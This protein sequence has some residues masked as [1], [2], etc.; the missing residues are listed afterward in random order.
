MMKYFFS[1]QLI[2]LIFFLSPDRVSAQSRPVIGRSVLLND[3][4][5]YQSILE[6]AHAGLYKY[7]SK[8]QIDSLF[9]HYRKQINDATD[10]CGFYRYLAAIMS[11]IGSL[12]DE[13]SLPD[14]LKKQLLA[15]QTYFPYPVKLVD[16]KLLL[17]IDGKELPAGSQIHSINGIDAGKIIQ[18]LY[19]YYTTDGFNI[20]GKAEGIN[21][22]FPWYYFMEYGP[23]TKFTINDTIVLPS[24]TMTQYTGLYKKRHS[25]LLDTTGSKSYT[26]KIIDSMETAI[27][28][29]PSFSLGNAESSTHAAY[30]KFLANSFA[31]LKSKAIRYLV[32]DIRGN[33][34][35]TDPNDLLTFSYLAHLPFKE[36]KEAFTIFQRIPYPQYCTD[37]TADIRELEENFLDEHNQYRDGRYYQNPAYSQWWRPD[38][39]AFQGKVYLLVDPAVASAASLFASMVK[40]EGNACV[41]GQE[42]M[43]GYY[44]HT[45]HNSLSYRLPGSGIAVDIS[46]V[47]LKQYVQQKREIP[48]G[49]GVIPDKIIHISTEDIKTNHDVVLDS[50]LLLIR[51]ARDHISRKDM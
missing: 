21:V 36:N 2:L 9:A 26:F 3:F 45:G 25:L 43:G 11:Y 15:E 4:D 37:D 24:V 13:V 33:G 20:T 19:K 38:S 14:E 49:A 5:L 51:T 34:G 48:Y 18:A 42:T 7:H 10:V 22:W 17:N 47:D 39:L 8:E 41:I 6:K 30:K 31:S 29:I 28:K 46:V 16:D 27:L 44:G 40:S 50:T 32:V 23:A 35:G 12:H 1:C